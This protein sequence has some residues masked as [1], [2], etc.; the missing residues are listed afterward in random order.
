MK[1]F[2]AFC[3]ALMM[4]ATGFQMVVGAQNDE[5]N[6]EP[7][8]WV[9]LQIGGEGFVTGMVF[10][11]AEKDLMYIRTDV[12][13]IYRW[14]PED[15]SWIPLCDS[16]SREDSSYYGCAG[17]AIDPQDT[18]VIYMACGSYSWSKGDVLKSTDRGTTWTETG[19]N[20]P[21]GANEASRGAS[22]CI[23][24]DPSN[25][26]I[27]YVGTIRD[28]VW[29]SEDGTKTWKQVTQIDCQGNPARNIAF[30]PTSV[31][32]GVC[33]TIYAG[34]YNQ[35]IYQSQDGGKTW[36]LMEGSPATNK[37]VEVTPSGVLY[38]AST[39]GLFRYEDGIWSDIAPEPYKGHEFN[40]ITI[41]L[42][43]ENIMMCLG[44]HSSQD[45]SYMNIPFWRSEDGGKTWVNKYVTGIHHTSQPWQKASEYQTSYSANSHTLKM[46]P[47]NNKEV[48]YCD[49]SAPHR[50]SD[51]TESSRQIWEMMYK[52]IEEVCP[53]K[54]IAPAEGKYRFIGAIADI[55]GLAFEDIFQPP[56]RT[57][58]ADRAE[59]YNHPWMM[60]SADIA[61][62]QSDPNI[63]LKVGIDWNSNGRME[64]SLDGSESWTT[65]E[66][67]RTYVDGEGNPTTAVPYGRCAV[68]SQLH[69]ETNAPVFVVI[70]C[71][72]PN[73]S[74]KQ[75]AE[76]QQTLP[77][78]SK[79]YGKTWEEVKGLPEGTNIMDDYWDK[80]T[81]IVADGVEGNRFYMYFDSTVYTS[82]DWGYTWEKTA[83]IPCDPNTAVI[84]AAPGVAGEV[85]ISS[86]KEAGLQHSSD[87]G[88]TFEKIEGVENVETFGFG[89]AAPDKDYPTL[90]IYANIDGVDGVFRST[91]EGKSFVRINDDA[92]K[93][94]SISCFLTGDMQTYGIVYLGLNGRGFV[95]G[96]PADVKA[97]LEAQS[98]PVVPAKP[99]ETYLTY[100]ETPIEFTSEP[101]I[102][103][104][105]FYV[106]IRDVV[107]QTGVLDLV[108]NAD[109]NSFTINRTEPGGTRT[110]TFQVNN[111][112]TM[113]N[114]EAVKLMDSP[115]LIGDRMYVALDDILKVFD[116][117]VDYDGE[118]K[119]Y[120]VT[121]TNV[122]AQ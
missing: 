108:W 76:G 90:Y 26:N 73:D 75:M 55:D 40:D 14:N 57:L 8:E 116:A 7:Y 68:S 1:R 38:T 47:F 58:R 35:G 111:K 45:N 65:I 106:P 56:T 32:D 81:P 110:V 99:Y 21:F 28:G 79:D 71:Y 92:H 62:C 22:E 93:F 107:D 98:E 113:V 4:V 31:K 61:L 2:F 117:T 122:I 19:L 85:W 42:N 46:N 27:V 74:D 66:N 36:T 6:D 67:V 9:G 37:A 101:Y 48:W 83:E 80:Y 91:D 89:K 78:V 64:Y 41:D 43:D 24:V 16:F 121:D 97:E 87:Y 112:D 69:P 114:G 54:G 104:S 72:N 18:D 52:G 10:H 3:M 88:K 12:G 50:C 49:F 96:M 5:A 94:G 82:D 23:M 109:E 86:T 34:V 102:M 115:R 120:T 105:Y 44:P 119:L 29:M 25:S 95:A 17:I 13:G 33:Q 39:T 63:I 60:S 51:I 53:R 30:D 20:K 84:S 77:L 15:E 11:P 100:N 59:F 103:A 70:P 118:K